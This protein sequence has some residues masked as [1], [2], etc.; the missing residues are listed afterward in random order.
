MQETVSFKLNGNPVTLRVDGDRMLLWVLRTDLSLTG[1]KCGCSEGWCG[2]CMVLIDDQAVF[3]CKI[4][5]REIHNAAVITIEGLGTD[6]SLHPLQKA[7]VDNDALQ[8]GFC[9]PGMILKAYSLLVENPDLSRK[10]IIDGMEGN[11][12]RCGAHVRIID[13]IEAAAGE[14]KGG[15]R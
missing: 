6:A 3:S 10:Q 11:L 12:C 15:V 1:T 7:F 2:A 5:V 8:C 4:P 14:M 9:T 13:A